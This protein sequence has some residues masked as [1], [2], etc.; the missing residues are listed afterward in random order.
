MTEAANQARIMQR[1]TRFVVANQAVSAY[2]DLTVR[3][4]GLYRSGLA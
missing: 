3:F 2:T 4:G 1:G